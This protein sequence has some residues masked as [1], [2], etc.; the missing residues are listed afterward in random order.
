MD[1][2]LSDI[3]ANSD[4]KEIERQVATFGIEKIVALIQLLETSNRYGEEKRAAV[5]AAIPE[6]I[7]LR[8]VPLHAPFFKS[9]AHLEALQ[10]KLALIA[11]E[12]GALLK[13]EMSIVEKVE[14]CFARGADALLFPEPLFEVDL[15]KPLL[16]AIHEQ[17]RPLIELTWVSGRIDL[18]DIYSEL[19]DR[20]SRLKLRI[21]ALEK[22]LKNPPKTSFELEESANA[23]EGLVSMGFAYPADWKTLLAELGEVTDLN[24]EAELIE[25]I[26]RHLASVGLLSVKNLKEKGLYTKEALISFLKKMR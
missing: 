11:T 15:K 4:N 17:I 20:C 7:F 26:S 18:I 13:N 21:S 19:N 24:E 23:I 5:I 6:G 1:N 3:L 8:L 16:A 14:E 22:Q 12:I 25:K 2:T 9:S 10:H